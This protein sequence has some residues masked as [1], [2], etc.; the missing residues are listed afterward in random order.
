M[1]K[2][3]LTVDSFENGKIHRELNPI[4]VTETELLEHIQYHIQRGIPLQIT[5]DG[6]Q[7]V[8][9]ILK[10]VTTGSQENLVETKIVLN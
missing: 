3:A 1:K 5:I 4:S 7:V 6:Q 9:Q 8:E 2:F 10:N